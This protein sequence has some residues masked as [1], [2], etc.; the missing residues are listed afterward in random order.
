MASA[1]G[2]YI[3]KLKQMGFHHV[4]L[5]GHIPL[6]NSL[7]VNLILLCLSS[8]LAWSCCP[9]LLSHQSQEELGLADHHLLEAGQLAQPEGSPRRCP[10]VRQLPQHLGLTGPVHR[11]LQCENP[12]AQLTWT[13]FPS[14]QPCSCQWYRMDSPTSTVPV[15]ALTVANLN[16][17]RATG[18]ASATSTQGC[19]NRRAG[20]PAGNHPHA[21]LLEAVLYWAT[22]S[23]HWASS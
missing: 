10:T 5:G 23:V 11:E 21:A 16:P 14:T 9:L 12:A 8:H 3:S 22:C 2:L 18:G 15:S 6:L 19:W 4:I 1:A 13:I 7:L 20:V 17:A